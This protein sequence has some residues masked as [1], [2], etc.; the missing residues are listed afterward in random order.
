MLWRRTIKLKRE[1]HT[2]HSTTLI[3]TYHYNW[4]EGNLEDVLLQKLSQVGISENP[5]SNEEIFKKLNEQEIIQKESEKYLK[6]LSAIR[7]ENLSDE[8]PP[9]T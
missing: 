2:K 9:I 6:C 7:V 8:S 5:R 3:E 4:V 1:L